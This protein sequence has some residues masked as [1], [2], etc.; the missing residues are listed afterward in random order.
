MWGRRTSRALFHSALTT[1]HSA[2]GTVRSLS[3]KILLLLVLSISLSSVGNVLLSAGMKQIG[4]VGGASFP[5][6]ALQTLS[7]RTI[8]LGIGALLLFFISYLMLLSWADYSYV[9]PAS[10]I[11]YAVVVLLGWLALGET[12][13]PLRWVGVASLRARAGRLQ[14]LTR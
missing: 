9:Q 11:G 7:S 10:A 14:S 12:V 6:V 5:A 2:T 13:S 3:A 4:E 8:W 1:P